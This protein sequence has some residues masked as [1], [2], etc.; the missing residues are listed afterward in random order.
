[1]T[2]SLLL[3]AFPD[4]DPFLEGDPP[5]GVGGL[6]DTCLSRRWFLDQVV[7]LKAARLP[8]LGAACLVCLGFGG[9]VFLDLG[10]T[11]ELRFSATIWHPKRLVEG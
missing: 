10:E 4:G 8:F 9:L 6:G 2:S 1:M 3:W 5:L 11:I 7:L